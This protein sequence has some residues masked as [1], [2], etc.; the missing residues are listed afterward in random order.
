MRWY[1]ALGFEVA[2]DVL[3]LAIGKR[4]HPRDMICSIASLDRNLS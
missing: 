4:F 2:N 1:K 3:P